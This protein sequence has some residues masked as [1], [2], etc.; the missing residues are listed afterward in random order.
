MEMAIYMLLTSDLRYLAWLEQK[1]WKHLKWKNKKKK[2]YKN[3]LVHFLTIAVEIDLAF[4]KSDDILSVFEVFNVANF[5][6]EENGF[7]RFFE[8]TIQMGNFNGKW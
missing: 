1:D 3:L 8:P 7:L 6:K 4:W 2:F 5:Y